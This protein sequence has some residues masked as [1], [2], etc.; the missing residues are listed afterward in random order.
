M[1]VWLGKC[2]GR[3]RCKDMYEQETVMVRWGVDENE[4]AKVGNGQSER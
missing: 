3:G 4:R 2:R 1:K